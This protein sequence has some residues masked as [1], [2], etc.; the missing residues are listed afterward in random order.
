MVL[1]EISSDRRKVVHAQLVKCHLYGFLGRLILRMAILF[2]V[3]NFQLE[4]F[5]ILSTIHVA[6][7]NTLPYLV[8][9]FFS[10]DLVIRD[11]TQLMSNRNSF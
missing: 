11:L 4:L 3:Y 5:H 1:L 7:V 8:S 9:N 6:V 2:A 10:N